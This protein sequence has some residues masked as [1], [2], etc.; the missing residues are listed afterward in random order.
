MGRSTFH[1]NRTFRDWPTDVAELADMLGLERFGVAGHSGGGPFVFAAAFRLAERLSGDLN[2]LDRIYFAVSQRFPALHD[3]RRRACRV[4]GQAHASAVRVGYCALGEHADK[5][6]LARP[7]VR[8]QFPKALREAFRSGGRGAAWEAGVC[9]RPWD[10]ALSDIPGPVHVWAGDADT[11]Y[12]ARWS[13][14]SSAS[15]AIR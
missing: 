6:V 1:K 8:E 14:R 2:R 12:R 9:Y 7:G 10:F 11:S 3:R 4:G 13:T 15:C 5:E